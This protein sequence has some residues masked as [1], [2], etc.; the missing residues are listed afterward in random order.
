VKNLMLNDEIVE[1]ASEGN[2]SIYAVETIDEAIEL[3]TGLRA[4]ERGKRG[5]FPK[6]TFNRRVEDRLR[7][8]AEQLRVCGEGVSG[9]NNSNNAEGRG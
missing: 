4:G 1:A 3:L 9:K 5:A 6:S 8:L 2:F 7:E